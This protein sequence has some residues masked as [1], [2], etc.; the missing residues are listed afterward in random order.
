MPGCVQ[1]T[2]HAH[3]IAGHVID[4]D[5]DQVVLPQLAAGRQRGGRAREQFEISG[6]GFIATG[7]DDAAVARMWEWVRYRVAFY[8]S[9]PA[10]WPVLACHGLEDLGE[11][12]NRMT[13]AGQWERIAAEVSDDV[14]ALFAASG[15]HDQL[16]A[17]IVARFGGA[18][19]AVFA[20]VATAV[21]A[22]LPPDLVQDIR[23]IPATFTGFAR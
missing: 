4:Q 16:A 21:P 17:A 19:D 6:G 22:D 11:K 8:A 23:R 5:L 14:V 2:Q 13:K 18:S 20:S 12:L 9:T 1:Q 3:Q 7:P 15:R 10:Y